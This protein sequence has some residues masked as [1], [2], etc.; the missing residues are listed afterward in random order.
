M[1]LIRAIGLI[2]EVATPCDKVISQNRVVFMTSNSR[3]LPFY[4]TAVTA[5][6]KLWI[7]PTR[8]TCSVFPAMLFIRLCISYGCAFHTPM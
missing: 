3:S 1:V 8:T 2:T 7:T 4:P 6:K 5:I